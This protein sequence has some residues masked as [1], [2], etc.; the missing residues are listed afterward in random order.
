MSQVQALEQQRDQANEMIER[1]KMAQRLANNPDFKKLILEEFCVQ[2]CARYA[3]L[4]ADPS[5]DAAAQ[6][7]SLNLAQSA[8]HLRRWL[9]VINTM[10]Q[11][12]ANLI[13]AL[14]DAI[15][16]ARAEEQEAD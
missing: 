16:E 2:E 6:K 1:C 3:Q 15:S 9:Q 10:S 12:A 4:S 11:Q 14:D 7:D 8:G 5:L 13:P